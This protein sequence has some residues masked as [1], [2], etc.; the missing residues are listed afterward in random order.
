[1]AANNSKPKSIHILFAC[2]SVERLR[3]DLKCSAHLHRIAAQFATEG[4]RKQEMLASP[5]SSSD[6]REPVRWR[7]RGSIDGN[8]AM[9]Q[10]ISSAIRARA[11]ATSRA[12][13]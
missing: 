11:V 9:H 13:F 3:P 6:A 1:M 8:F 4:V 5:S 7:G 2:G 10:S 12:A